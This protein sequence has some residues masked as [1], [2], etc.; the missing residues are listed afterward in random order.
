M[1]TTLTGIEPIPV[2]YILGIAQTKA[3]A[4]QRR[5]YIE[6][7]ERWGDEQGCTEEA[8]QLLKRLRDGQEIDPRKMPREFM[9][10]FRQPEVAEKLIEIIRKIDETIAS[11][12]ENWTW[13][14]VM[15]VMCD[16]GILYKP[17]INRFDA[18]ICSMIPNK[19]RDTVRKNGDYTYIIE[20][21]EEPWT[22]W[23]AESYLNPTLAAERSIC[24]QIAL[25]FAP[26]LTR[27]IRLEF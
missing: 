5:P 26:I 27:T 18:I 13:A 20:E 24:N 17:T 11:K 21:Q 6:L 12:Q 15:R 10:R 22:L 7:I 19:G 25:V 14:H 23:P 3:T 9:P 16:E 8:C 2:E 1:K 4:A